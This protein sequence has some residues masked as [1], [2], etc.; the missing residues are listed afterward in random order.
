MSACSVFDS[1]RSLTKFNLTQSTKSKKIRNRNSFDATWILCFALH[2]KDASILIKLMNKSVN[3]IL[4]PCYLLKM[5]PQSDHWTIQFFTNTFLPFKTKKNERDGNWFIS[6]SGEHKE[7]NFKSGHCAS[8]VLPHKI[9][10]MFQPVAAE[11]NSN[12]R[13]KQ[14]HELKLWFIPFQTNRTELKRINTKPNR[15]RC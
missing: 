14:K 13:I 9:I 7:A 4:E 11:L 3:K 5:T 10:Y 12:T 8:W 1:L 15:I 2:T 6:E